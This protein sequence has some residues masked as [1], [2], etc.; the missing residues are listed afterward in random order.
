MAGTD[1]QG[2]MKGPRTTRDVM[3]ATP[4]VPDAGSDDPVA[5]ATAKATDAVEVDQEVA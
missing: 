3:T 2:P 4:A 5:P 1:P